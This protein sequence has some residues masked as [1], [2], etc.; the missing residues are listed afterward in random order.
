SRARPNRDLARRATPHWQA[1]AAGPTIE[2]VQQA[3]LTY[4]GL[5]AEPIRGLP[6]R[7]RLSAALPQA[8]FKVVR[9]LDRSGRLAA[10][11]TADEPTTN[12]TG[13]DVRADALRLQGELR[14][15]LDA[16]V[17]HPREAAL[18]RENRAAARERQA[19]LERVTSLYFARQRAVLEARLG[20]PDDTGAEAA[21]ELAI[22]EATAGL[23]AL[24]GWVFA[25]RWPS[26]RHLEARSASD[27]ISG[28][29]GDPEPLI[30]E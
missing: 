30:D 1:L 7:A 18:W 4:A 25:T 17:F 3:A 23:D 15:H 22:A 13:T 8:T 29:R 27:A 9:D 28:E 5:Q 26:A 14:W 19:L 16:L 6:Q 21:A 11:Y 12:L 2:Q 10:R 20:P 24:T